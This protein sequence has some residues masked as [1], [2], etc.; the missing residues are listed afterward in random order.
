LW[1]SVW[2]IKLS[3]MSVSDAKRHRMVRT[4][5]ENRGLVLGDPL[6]GHVTA[7]PDDGSQHEVNATMMGGDDADPHTQ[8]TSFES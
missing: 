3:G 2:L 8:A 6:R 7:T 4:V 1:D 5:S